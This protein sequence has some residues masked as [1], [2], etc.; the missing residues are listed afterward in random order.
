MRTTIASLGLFA[1]LANCGGDPEPGLSSRALTY[2][3]EVTAKDS[4]GK[5]LGCST[6][7]TNGGLWENTSLALPLN[8]QC[9]DK[10]IATDGQY[11]VSLGN[12][13]HSMQM[14][15]RTTLSCLMTGSAT[16]SGKYVYPPLPSY[17][18]FDDHPDWASDNQMSRL[19][20]GTI[21]MLRQGIRLDY[22]PGYPT[23]EADGYHCL[24][25]T[26]I[27]VGIG[28]TDGDHCV[29]Y[30]RGAEYLYA[31]ADCGATWALRGD[32]IDPR[33]ALYDS[34]AYSNNNA[35]CDPT[36]PGCQNWSGS[37][38]DR[39]EL[40]VHPWL[41]SDN[42]QNVYVTVSHAAGTKDAAAA[43]FVSKDS[44]NTFSI[45]N[46]P[47]TGKSPLPFGFGGTVMTSTEDGS[48]L[49]FNCV[50]TPPLGSPVDTG[51]KYN[52]MLF[53]YNPA[54][55][56]LSQGVS[57]WTGDCSEIGMPVS[58]SGMAVR[59]DDSQNIARLG[60]GTFTVDSV[61]HTGPK[62]RVIYPHSEGTCSTTTTKSCGTNLDCPSGACS[63]T[64]TTA[65]SV[66]GDC[67]K[68]ET[69]NNAEVC[70]ARQVMRVLAV[71]TTGIGTSAF[72][73]SVLSHQTITATSSTG[74]VLQ[75]TSIETDRNELT[76]ASQKGAIYYYETTTSNYLSGNS[77]WGPINATVQSVRGDTTLSGPNPLATASWSWLQADSDS[78]G[79]G[80]LITGDYERGAFFYDGVNLNFIPLWLQ[81]STT[82]DNLSLE[83]SI[84]TVAP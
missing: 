63:M 61:T 66:N 1:S 24:S 40:Y 21:L 47:L 39:N 27:P 4:L 32:P 31:S 18:G 44:G 19:K 81:S 72:T 13:K 38:L 16:C 23:L 36:L 73:A 64:T 3:A 2:T 57:L 25:G 43:L 11:L 37:G 42:T 22:V 55:N 84:V 45:V 59:G 10:T 26:P 74:S 71:G 20:D 75:A 17:A 34:G 53:S 15:W 68:G 50:A 6:C 78:N 33:S 5:N 80:W 83:T 51:G 65:C 12:P 30:P 52:P 58:G 54:T 48:L 14:I 69:C 56:S 82:I 9:A 35:R 79:F 76:T 70:N 49:L 41:N 67:P 8:T 60:V 7:G 46:D 29:D 62:V 77:G 28:G